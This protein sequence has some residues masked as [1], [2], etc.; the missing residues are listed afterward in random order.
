MLP[1]INKVWPASVLACLACF[2]VLSVPALAGKKPSY[3]E[4]K[5]IDK[6]ENEACLR[7]LD[8]Y[9]TGK[10][11]NELVL[12]M[13]LVEKSHNAL[14]RKLD[15]PQSDKVIKLLPSICSGDE[16]IVIGIADQWRREKEHMRSTYFAPNKQAAANVR[17]GKRRGKMPSMVEARVFGILAALN[18]IHAIN[19]EHYEHRRIAPHHKWPKE[20]CP[21]LT[22][23]LAISAIKSKLRLID[24]E[25]TTILKSYMD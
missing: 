14:C 8:G 5:I 21:N 7:C 10:D 19:K 24:I 20:S 3:I 9:V 23:E 13:K 6:I 16:K 11:F 22:L 17:A 25:N 1:Q 12:L 15:V 4:R 2:M 18:R